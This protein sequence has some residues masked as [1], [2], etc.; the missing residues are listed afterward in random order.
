MSL[1]V[2]LDDDGLPVGLQIMAP[3]LGE[4]AMFRVARALEN[5]LGFDPVGRGP[6]SLTEALA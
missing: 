1:P 6:N 3:V 4:H 2:G 5:D